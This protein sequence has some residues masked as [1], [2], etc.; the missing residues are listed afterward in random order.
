MQLHLSYFGNLQPEK[1]PIHCRVSLG[2]EIFQ[3][4]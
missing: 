2:G 4:H 1:L 3:N